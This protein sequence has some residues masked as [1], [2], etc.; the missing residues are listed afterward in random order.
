MLIN[1]TY[2]NPQYVVEIG[3]QKGG[4]SVYIGTMACVS[5]KFLF[6]T[7]DISK[8]DWY[9]RNKDT[10][11]NRVKNNY[12]NNRDEKLSKVKEYASKNQDKIKARQSIKITCEC[13]SVFG[14]YTI[15]KH[16]QTVIHQEYLKIIESI[17]TEFTNETSDRRFKNS[18]IA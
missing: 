2:E 3:S 13:G 14:K 8:K 12:V 10:V 1:I 18:H 15:K 7:F 6:H 4:L 9:N 16:L 11:I 17:H 5:E